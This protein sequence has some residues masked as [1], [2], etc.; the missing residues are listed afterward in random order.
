MHGPYFT[1]IGQHCSLD[2]TTNNWDTI[3]TYGLA[4][5]MCGQCS[6]TGPRALLSLPWHLNFSSLN[7]SFRGEVSWDTGACASAHALSRLPG[8]AP[9]ALPSPLHC[10]YLQS[11]AGG[12]RGQGEGCGGD[13]WLPRSRCGVDKLAI[14]AGVACLSWFG[15]RPLGRRDTWLDFS[16]SHPARALACTRTPCGGP[17]G[18]GTTHPESVHVPRGA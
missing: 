2:V 11:P 18:R 17:L 1:S 15:Q 7:L 9:K 10:Y 4:S 13:S 14:P 16:R 8:M 6:L 12:G 5:G 3:P